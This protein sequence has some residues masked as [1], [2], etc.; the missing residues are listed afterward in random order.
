MS[1]LKLGSLALI[2]SL[3]ASACQSSPSFTYAALKT[4]DSQSMNVV[5]TVL[6]RAMNRARVEI[7]PGDLTM[8]STISVLPPGLSPD[9]D[10]STVTPALFD[11]MLEGSVCYV[12]RRDSGDA[13]QLRGVACRPLGA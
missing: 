9:E 2:G 3:V 4:A 5:M 6:A 11:I 7:G 8:T 10:R 13:F 12:V 1:F